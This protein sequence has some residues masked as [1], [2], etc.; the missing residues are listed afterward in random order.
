MAFMH[1]S[2]GQADFGDQGTRP[3]V[4]PQQ[5]ILRNSE[6]PTGAAF[7]LLS[8]TFPWGKLAVAKNQQQL[9]GTLVSAIALG[10]AVTFI[11]L[12]ILTSQIVLGRIVVSSASSGCGQWAVERTDNASVLTILELGL[13]ATLDADNYVQNCYFGS[14]KSAIFD[15]ERLISQSIPFSVSNASCPFSSDVCRTDFSL[16]I[17]TGN[18]SLAQLGINTKLAD[19]LYFRRRSICAP[20]REDL[21]HVET[22]TSANLSWLVGEEKLSFYRFYT[23]PESMRNSDHIVRHD[24]HSAGY[25]LTAY[26]YPLNSYERANY[27]ASPLYMSDQLSDGNHGPSIVLLSGGGITFDKPYDDPLWSVHAEVEIHNTTF[28]GIDL[29]N[30]PTMYRMDR[31]LNII[32]CDERLQICA[33]TTDRCMPWS[34]LYLDGLNLTAIGDNAAHGNDTAW[35]LATPLALLADAI[36]GTSIPGSIAGRDSSSALR[37][38]RYMRG[39]QHFYLEPEQWKTE[40]TY[41]FALA[42][43]RLQLGIYNTIERPVGVDL[44]RTVNRW[45]DTPM[46]SLCG[47]VKYRSANHTSLSFV[48]VVV[49]VVVSITII[50]L[51]FFEV[52]IDLMPSRWLKNR[53]LQWGSS[54]NLALLE[55]KENLEPESTS[56]GGGQGQQSNGKAGTLNEVKPT[57]SQG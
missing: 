35:D 55:A 2:N 56:E 46:M 44:N 8:Y 26:H 42:L 11:A 3:K 32:G 43:A 21:F 31:V 37:A 36:T 25:E 52:V 12:S 1:K 7:G 9:K 41:W 24:N 28:R 17:D 18:V 19:Q 30:V 40:V 34:G 53:V 50:I 47:R 14:T 51:S 13:N 38:S 54:D 20:I 29:S 15:C 6:T 16:A 33:K 5:V 57:A 4:L 23:G 22:Y 45:A 48:G 27:L 49:V 10:H 39:G